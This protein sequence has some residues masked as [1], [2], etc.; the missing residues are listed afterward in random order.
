MKC[1]LATGN[2][3]WVGGI[4]FLL[5]CVAPTCADEMVFSEAVDYQPKQV[6]QGDF[7]ASELYWSYDGK[8]PYRPSRAPRLMSQVQCPPA[9]AALTARGYWVGTLD[10]AGNC[11]PEGDP[12][13]WLSG[14]FV[15][16][17]GDMP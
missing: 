14:N 17:L 16:Y 3:A 9:K 4:L 11:G 10:D 12:K 6:Y 8:G 7:A 5:M 15:N 1:L 13:V 2:R